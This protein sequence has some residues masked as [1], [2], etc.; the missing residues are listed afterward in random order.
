MPAC[1]KAT[2]SRRSPS[3]ARRN[4]WPIGGLAGRRRKSG[5]RKKRRRRRPPR[6][7]PLRKRQPVPAPPKANPPFGA[8]V[9]LVRLE[10]ANVTLVPNYAATLFRAN[11]TLVRNEGAFFLERT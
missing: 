9:T 8:N 11:V 3:T 2:R 6:K 4:C 7:R 10:R 1:V 5:R